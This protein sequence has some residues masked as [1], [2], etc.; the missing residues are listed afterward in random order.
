M[1][2]LKSHFKTY[3][4]N[5]LITKHFLQDFRRE[6]VYCTDDNENAVSWPGDMFE[7]LL[8]TGWYASTLE[9]QSDHLPTLRK[10]NS[11]FI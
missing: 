8:V 7:N 9:K 6:T 11:G 5:L 2:I 4:N 1:D 10:V 3:Q